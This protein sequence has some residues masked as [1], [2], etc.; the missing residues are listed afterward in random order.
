[1]CLF[2]VIVFFCECVLLCEY[3]SFLHLLRTNSLQ[4]VAFYPIAHSHLQITLKMEKVDDD[5]DGDDD[6]DDDE[7]GGEEEEKEVSTIMSMMLRVHNMRNNDENLI[8]TV[9][10][11]R[12]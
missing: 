5:D 12:A 6:D 7:G 1:M 3:S 2:F 8:S 10:P 9:R 4:N 11:I